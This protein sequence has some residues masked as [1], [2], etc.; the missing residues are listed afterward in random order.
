MHFTTTRVQNYDGLQ[1]LLSVPTLV[2]TICK[3][4]AALAAAATARVSFPTQN[5]LQ[6]I[7]RMAVVLVRLGHG[8]ADSSTAGEELHLGSSFQC[9]H[10]DNLADSVQIIYLYWATRLLCPHHKGASS[11]HPIRVRRPDLWYQIAFVD[12]DTTVEQSLV[13]S[14]GGARGM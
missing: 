4:V 12:S 14:A 7:T 3:L 11:P 6:A 13:S 9:I 2:F 10:V 8:D 1:I 5:R